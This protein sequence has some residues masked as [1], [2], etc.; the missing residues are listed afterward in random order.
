MV[1]VGQER[2]ARKL[3]YESNG[4]AATQ[5]NASM[6]LPQIAC[7]TSADT[8]GSSNETVCIAVAEQV[9]QCQS[10]S[11]RHLDQT[12]GH[13]LNGSFHHFTPV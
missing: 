2:V 3:N 9:A 7:I 12:R 8:K 10:L 4:V 11:W 6:L 1:D 5:T 13:P